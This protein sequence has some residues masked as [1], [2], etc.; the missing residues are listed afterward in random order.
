MHHDTQ[1]ESV[2][3]WITAARAK[4]CKHARRQAMK[5]HAP[6]YHPPQQRRTKQH[7]HPNDQVIHM[8][9]DESGWQLCRAYTKEDKIKWQNEGQCYECDQRGHMAANCPNKKKRQTRPQYGN[10]PS[11]FGQFGQQ[12]FQPCFYPKPSFQKGRQKGF[13][14]FNKPRGRPFSSKIRSAHIEEVDKGEEDDEGGQQEER[15]D[16]PSLAARTARLSDKQKEEWL[17]EIDRKSTRL[18]SSHR[19]L[20]RMPSSA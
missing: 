10:T 2:E 14:K 4:S 12:H 3:E 17:A 1:P 5:H 8:D 15:E 16:A 18:N 11:K 13:C 9:I 6:S 20:S 19:S 7:V